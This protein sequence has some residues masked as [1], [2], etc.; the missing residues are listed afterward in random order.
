MSTPQLTPTQKTWAQQRKERLAR[1]GVGP[2]LA[3]KPVDG[4]ASEQTF[5]PERHS[6][7]SEEITNTSLSAKRVWI[8]DHQGYCNGPIK[9][10]RNMTLSKRQKREAVRQRRAAIKDTLRVVLDVIMAECATEAGKDVTV[11]AMKSD[12]RR[13]SVAA[14]RMKFYYRAVTETDASFVMIAA[15]SGGR[16][17]TS[18]MYGLARYC[19]VNKIEMPRGI[20]GSKYYTRV[21]KGHEKALEE[22]EVARKAVEKWRLGQ[23]D[24]EPPPPVPGREAYPSP[25]NV[26]LP[27]LQGG[28]QA[29]ETARPGQYPVPA[30]PWVDT[31]SL[32]YWIKRSVTQ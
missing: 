21:L 11:A 15:A 25:G 4:P 2:K 9:V 5:D 31:T 17:H 10:W 7:T 19:V 20:N 14:A 6:A 28:C 26:A 30:I 12:V 27:G 3:P 29:S 1:M 22:V 23:V 13:R 24:A 16:D 32:N 8:R 18:V